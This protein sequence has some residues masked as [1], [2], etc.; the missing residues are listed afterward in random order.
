[1][2]AHGSFAIFGATELHVI[3][4]IW[5]HG[6][7]TVRDVYE[8]LCVE[9]PIAYNTVQTII[10]RL[11]EKGMVLRDGQRNHSYAYRACFT[12]EE[13]LARAVQELLSDLQPSPEERGRALAALSA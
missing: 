9:R 13:L 1:M 3:Q 4:I 2:A 5:A 10:D 8:A 7:P 12:K 6:R 11:R